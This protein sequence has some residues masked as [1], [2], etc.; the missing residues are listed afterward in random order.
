MKPIADLVV[1]RARLWTDGSRQAGSDAL[2]VAGGRILAVGPAPE[3]EELAGPGTPRIDAAGGTLTPGFADAHI[4]LVQWARSLTEVDLT[5]CDSRDEVL[6]R[7]ADHVARR[8]GP[9]PVVG[10]GWDANDWSAAPDCASLDRVTGGRAALLYSKD[11][12]AAWV[13]SAAL[14]IA[15]IT[16]ATADPAGGVIRRDGRGEP[17]G[18]LQEHAVALCASLVAERPQADREAVLTAAARLHAAGVTSVHDFEGPKAQRVLHGLARGGEPPLRVLMHLA[19]GALDPA[20]EAGI[21]SG[22]G[23]EWFRLGAVKLFADGTLGSRT[24]AMIE[25][26]EGTTDTGLDLLPPDELR[27]LVARAFAAGLSVAVHAIGDRAV[28]GAL[29]AFESARG[30]IAHLA[31]PPRIEHLQLVRPEDAA[32]L[33]RLGVAAS[34]QPQ[35][36]VSDIDLAER[37][38]GARCRNAYPWRALLDAGARLAFGSDAPVEPPVPAAGLAAAVTRRRPGRARAFVPEQ[39]IGLDEALTAYTEGAARLAGWWPAVGSLRPGSCAD[40]VVWSTDLHAAG[41]ED[42]AQARPRWTVLGGRP[43]HGEGV[44]AATARAGAAAV[45]PERV[46]AGGGR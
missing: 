41:A 38:W 28:R 45:A 22:I 35:H 17:T 5:G 19:H 40:F 1:T 7:V 36:C 15:G 8:P 32:R 18:L 2:A 23:D 25:P 21:A 44:P 12:H 42:L 11:F 9:D 37:H 46:A 27:D 16:A 24:A 14:A 31:L 33:A 34:M 10:R 43:V 39:C 3:V 6:R 26:Y 20:R 29:D 30:H 13:N 4:H